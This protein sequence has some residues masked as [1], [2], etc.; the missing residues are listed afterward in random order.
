LES[1]TTIATDQARTGAT[2]RGSLRDRAAILRRRSQVE[3]R[4][5]VMT[6]GG[7]TVARI[8]S[9]RLMDSSNERR[10][11]HQTKTRVF[12]NVTFD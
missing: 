1:H 4:R 10:I 9:N 7:L 11:D 6:N 8:R 3:M 12:S 2:P 5:S